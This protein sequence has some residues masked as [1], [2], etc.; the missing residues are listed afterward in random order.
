MTNQKPWLDENGNVYSNE[1]LRVLK[2]GW[3]LETWEAFLKSDV[4][5]A[6]QEYL[7]DDPGFVENSQIGYSESYQ[8][9]ASSERF[10]MLKEQVRAYLNRLT[11][12]EQKIIQAIFWEGKSQ[13]DIARELKVSRAAIFRTRDRALKKLGALFVD[14]FLSI[15]SFNPSQGKG[16][17]PI[18]SQKPIGRGE[19]AEKQVER[20]EAC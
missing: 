12:K 11:L 19:Y 3:N 10:P 20:R 2:D 18:L 13:R 14:K 7:P 9:M 16:G 6:C 8:D 4:E 17:H 15:N 5:K 1:K